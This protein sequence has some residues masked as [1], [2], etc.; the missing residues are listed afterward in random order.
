MG[1]EQNLSKI[2]VTD[3]L[4]PADTLRV[5]KRNGIGVVAVRSLGPRRPDGR[6][7]HYLDQSIYEELVN[8]AREGVRFYLLLDEGPTPPVAGSGPGVPRRLLGHGPGQ[9]AHGRGAHHHGRV[10]VQRGGP[11][12]PR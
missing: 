11:C 5:L 2:F 7:E 3:T 9:G 10:R 1:G 4:P 12:T 8:L 6:A